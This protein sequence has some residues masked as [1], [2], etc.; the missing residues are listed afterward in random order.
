MTKAVILHSIKDVKHCLKHEL[1]KGAILFSAN[2]NV[3]CYLRDRYE[4]KCEDLCSHF[5]RQEIFHIQESMLQLSNSLLEELDQ[6]IS[7]ILNQQLDL[8]ISYFKPLYSFIAA[9]QLSL[10]FLL[11]ESLNRVLNQFEDIMIYEGLMGPLKCSTDTFFNR[12]FSSNCFQTIR[13][14]NPVQEEIAIIDNVEINEIPE[15][16]QQYDGWQ[17]N[18]LSKGKKTQNRNVLILGPSKKMRNFLQDMEKIDV[19]HVDL[20]IFRRNKCNYVISDRIFPSAN[21]LSSVQL[22]TSNIRNN[23]CYLYEIIIEDFCLNIVQ[24]LKILHFYKMLHEK[25][26][27]SNLFWESAPALDIGALLVEYFM[28]NQTTQV[29]GIQSSPTFFVGQL[30]SCYDEVAIF[31]RCHTFLTRG[32]TRE[33]LEDV[34]NDNSCYMRIVPPRSLT[35][36]VGEEVSAINDKE[37]VDIVFFITP[38]ASFIQVGLMSGTYMQ[39]EIIELLDSVQTKTVHIVIQKYSDY[40]NTAMLSKLESL[41]NITLIRADVDKYLSKYSPKLIFAEFPSPLF[42]DILNENIPIVLVK[43]PMYNLTKFAFNEIIKRF[44]YVEKLDDVKKILH[45]FSNGFLE[46]KTNVVYKNKFLNLEGYKEF[47]YQVLVSKGTT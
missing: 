37:K 47:I 11:T 25:V 31:S 23:L 5:S 24:Y 7:P 4:L 40:G 29:I 45:E 33:E 38:T 36:E 15:L 6:Q 12:M 30:V 28:S 39:E 22:L 21:S 3:V 10:Y 34:Y 42:E 8:H 16:L 18:N 19:Y 17:T 13:Y 26:P 20:E 41:K 27:I 35:E 44:Y 46:T 1:H 43:N 14:Y 9:R 2:V 32:Y